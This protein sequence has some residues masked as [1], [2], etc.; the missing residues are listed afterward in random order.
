MVGVG[1]GGGGCVGGG[2]TSCSNPGVAG[3][4][5]AVGCGERDSESAVVS[6]ASGT[7][8]VSATTSDP[9]CGDAGRDDG[10]AAAWLGLASDFGVSRSES[11][12]ASVIA[13]YVSCGPPCGVLSPPLARCGDD[14]T[15]ACLSEGNPGCL[16][17][18]RAGEGTACAALEHAVDGRGSTDSAE[19]DLSFA[20]GLS[21]LPPPLVV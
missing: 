9:S 10:N 15:A 8:G 19:S 12:S 13:V 16:A 11:D 3:A 1:V 20:R 2:A 7:S 18:R 21:T 5:A 17:S 14:E 4:P 6:P